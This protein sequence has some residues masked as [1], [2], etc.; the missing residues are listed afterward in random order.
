MKKKT[1]NLI[2]GVVGGVETIAVAV[3]TYLNPAYATAIN[4]STLI[5]GTAITEVCSQFVKIEG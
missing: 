2:A 4:T 3:V 1:F 5:V